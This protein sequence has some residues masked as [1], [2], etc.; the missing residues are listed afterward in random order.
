MEAQQVSLFTDGGMLSLGDEAR[1]FNAAETRLWEY[2][3]KLRENGS[4]ELVPISRISNDLK[5][6]E[7]FVANVL[8]GSGIELESGED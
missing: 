6:S 4:K 2:I 5:V 7:T 8:E 3:H 1:Y